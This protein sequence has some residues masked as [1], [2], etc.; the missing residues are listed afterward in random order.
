MA[1]GIINRFPEGMG[2]PQYDAVREKMDIQNDPPEGMI[3]HSAGE[4]EGRFQVFNVWET[5]ENHERF[6]TDRLRPTQVEVIGEERLA[7]LP[8]AEIVKV[9][10]H[11]YFIP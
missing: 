1:V 10:I 11:N 7:E 6:V 8:D 9:E 3:F 2:A 4:L 5:L